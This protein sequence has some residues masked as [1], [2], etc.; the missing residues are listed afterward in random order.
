MDISDIRWN[1]PARQKILDDADNV[2]REAVVA[3]ARE[4][5]G[6]SSDEAFAQIN[7]RIKDRFIDYEPGPDIR[8]Y[9][10]AIAA[11]EVP[12]DDAA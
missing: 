11:G 3:I 4:S 6:I 7:A 8:T 10:D 2:L 1:E 12:T 5:D 9:A